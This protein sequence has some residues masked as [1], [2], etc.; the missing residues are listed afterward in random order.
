MKTFKD[1]QFQPH[2]NSSLE[3]GVQAKMFFPNG[4]GVSVVRFKVLGTYAS[5]TNN[6]DEWEMAILKGNDSKFEIC[7]DT[8]ITS[9]VLGY[10]SDDEVSEIMK[11]VQKLP[12]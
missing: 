2:P 8:P 3:G 6:E 4:Y 11:R 7:Y 10:L 12:K 5:Y 1:L 9:D